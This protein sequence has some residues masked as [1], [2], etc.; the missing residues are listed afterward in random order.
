MLRLGVI[1]AA[2]KRKFHRRLLTIDHNVH[3]RRHLRNGFAAQ[4]NL[5]RH[6]FSIRIDRLE[7]RLERRRGLQD[8]IR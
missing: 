7:H 5:D 1:P 4:S 2:G 3:R 6:P 8:A